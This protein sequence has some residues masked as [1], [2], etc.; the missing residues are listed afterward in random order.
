MSNGY[1]PRWDIDLRAGKR[2]EWLAE[3]HLRIDTVEVKHDFRALDTGNLYIEDRCQRRDGWHP[4]GVA[5]S[6]ADAWAFVL[7]ERGP[8]VLLIGVDRLRHL[9]KVF[10]KRRGSQPDGSHPTEGVLV[11]L[12]AVTRK[13]VAA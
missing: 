4:S 13:L 11:P 1:D 2:G 7:D 10:A 9:V 6:E 12:A 5:T 8:V 3:A